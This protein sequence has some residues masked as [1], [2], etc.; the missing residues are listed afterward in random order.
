MAAEHDGCSAGDPHPERQSVAGAGWMT[1]G[2]VGVM[3][4]S[5]KYF[6]QRDFSEYFDKGNGEFCE[7][8]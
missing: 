8:L 1:G 6:D 5:E 3:V 4:W 2:D 7:F